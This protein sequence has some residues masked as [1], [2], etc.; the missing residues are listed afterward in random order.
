MLTIKIPYEGIDD[1]AAK[2]F[3]HQIMENID[4]P[5]GVS[6]KVQE[7]HNDK[8]PRKVQFDIK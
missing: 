1:L 6:V 5:K 4:L 8:P 7:V 2:L 3:Y